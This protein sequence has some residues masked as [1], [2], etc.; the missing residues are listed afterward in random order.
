[1]GR[2]RARTPDGVTLP[3]SFRARFGHDT[4]AVNQPMT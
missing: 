3:A 4:A 1:M 2:W